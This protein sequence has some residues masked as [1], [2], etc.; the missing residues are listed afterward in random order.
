M[1][2]GFLLKAQFKD[3]KRGLDKA[4]SSNVEAAPT[5]SEGKDVKV[6]DAAVNRK[7]N[8]ADSNL[9]NNVSVVLAPP[10]GFKQGIYVKEITAP[11]E[12]RNPPDNSLIMTTLPPYEHPNLPNREDGFT[13]CFISGYIKKI[14]L[15]YPGFPA[16]VP[17]PT[18]P[19]FRIMET[20]SKGLGV[21]TTRKVLAGEL[22]LAERPLLITPC[23]LYSRDPTTYKSGYT[24]AQMSQIAWD[25]REK[26]LEI[27]IGRFLDD[28]E[29]ARV[30]ALH[31]AHLDDGSGPIL[32]IVRTNGF[33][34]P[35]E[36]Q[37][38]GLKGDEGSY[39]ILCDQGSRINHSCSPNVTFTWDTAS[40]SA[41]FQL[42]RDVEA[43]EEITFSYCGPTLLQSRAL[44][45]KALKSYGFEC[46]CTAC[47]NPQV[48]D[49]R[50][51][52][53]RQAFGH[54]TAGS[55]AQD[56]Q[57]WLHLPDREFLRLFN[58]YMDILELEG[59][60]GTIPYQVCC[61]LLRSRYIWLADEKNCV[62]YTRMEATA[63]GRNLTDGEHLTD[64][65]AEDQWGHSL[66]TGHRVY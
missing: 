37:E 16:A 55:A 38:K 66:K 62:K 57:Q 61:L 31:N 11:Q 24:N 17:R 34:G 22:L 13:Q 20:E 21:F 1:K 15:N 56:I 58:G 53:L 42:L 64:C 10:I 18:S 29:R 12:K 8:A 26:E 33:V 4:T 65:K 48:S 60:Q 6:R 28:K 43:G 30:M 39:S 45:Q 3:E 25:E 36:L 19:A 14:A 7:G 54:I 44:R 9:E 50:R 40:F 2:R 47:L 35:E 32:G 52:T 41:K 59:L 23:A 27:L 63:R 51:E 49:P 5:A 46:T